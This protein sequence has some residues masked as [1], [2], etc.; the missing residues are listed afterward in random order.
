MAPKGGTCCFLLILACAALAKPPDG[1]PDIKSDIK[2]ISRKLMKKCL[3]NGFPEPKMLPTTLF[4]NCDSA[5]AEL[6]SSYE[7]MVSG[8]SNKVDV[9]TN[10]KCLLATIKQMRNS[11]M[12]PSCHMQAILA[13]ISWEMLTKQSENMTS[14]EYDT[15]LGASKPAL[16]MK[17]PSDVGKRQNLKKLMDMLRRNLLACLKIK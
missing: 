7:S 2:D 16:G 6:F 12:A 14:E 4:K 8:S 10:K 1:N 11:S 9:V 5:K 13:S 17:L 15:L 3:K